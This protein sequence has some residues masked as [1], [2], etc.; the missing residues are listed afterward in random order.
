MRRK[1]VITLAATASL[2]AGGVAGAQAGPDRI[3]L[4]NG[5]QPEGIAAGPGKSLYV[6]SIP[7]GAVL[8]VNARTGRREEVVAGAEG[9]AAI[10]LKLDRRRRIFVA[11]GPTGKVFVY[12][13]RNGSLLKEFAPGRAGNTFINDVTVTRRAAYFTDSRRA[14][15]Y[16]VDRRLRRVSELDVSDIPAADEFNLNGIAAAPN[17]RTLVAVHSSRGE[18]WR[19]DARTGNATK[20]DL[21]SA[22]VPNG[23]GLLLNGRRLYVV[24]NQDNKIAVIRLS[25][26]LRS[27]RLERTI[28]SDGFD[29]PTT[30]A[31]QS[32]RLYV[33][34]ARFGTN[35]TPQ[36]PYWVSKVK[37]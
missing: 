21:G 34:N 5:W 1:L 7:T 16:V 30:V 9:R 13:A 6:G 36:T 23:D 17:G 24:Q 2:A 37:P 11:G 32:G 25:K 4:P 27:G 26:S 35:P 15:L 3:A 18:L 33:V 29:V 19:I 31:R 8:R 28:T 12:N 22:S 20:V 14:V 10:G